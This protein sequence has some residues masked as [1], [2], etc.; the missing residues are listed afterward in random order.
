MPDA[1]P[2]TQ[3]EVADIVVIGAGVSG[4][5]VLNSSK[6]YLPSGS[7]AVLIDG[8]PR[9]GGMWNIAYDYVRL[10]QPHPMFT[11]GAMRWD[12]DKPR[13]YLARRDEV[14]D[15]LARAIGRIEDKFRLDA[16]FGHIVTS[17]VEIQT[18][19]GPMA[20]VTFHPND[21][22]D[23]A[24]TIRARTAVHSAGV[25][26]HCADPLPISSDRVLSIIPQ[27]LGETLA[28][29]PG[30]PVY[31]VGG[32][33]TGMDTILAAAD[34][35]SRAVHLVNG[36][37]TN[38]ISRDVVLPGGLRRWIS[39]RPVSMMFRDLATTF[40]G[41]NEN[42][43]IDHV[44]A[45]YSTA[46]DV[47]NRT[48]LYGLQSMSERARIDAATDVIHGY[49]ED[50]ED[51]PDGPVLRLRDGA[52]LPVP[53]G[54]VFVNCTG[55][56]FRFETMTPM[57]PLISPGGAVLSVNIR[58][59]FH[60][61]SSVA[62]FFTPHL[63]FRGLLRDNGFYALDHE[64]LFRANRNA[65]VGASAAQAYLNQV[66]AMQ[67]L[68]ISVLDRCGLDMDR[69]FPLPRRLL[70]MHRMKSGAA[71]DLPHCKAVLDRVAD[72]FDVLCREIT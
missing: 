44:R 17:C 49:F 67:V 7:K 3:T 18:P 19:D 24:R 65:W 31:V 35:P 52:A 2:Q 68:P 15:H 56:F 60:F 43:L 45:T 58:N 33:K 61:L 10:H 41:D 27:D 64:V 36:S 29:H 34:D 4:L 59:A 25:D 70:A 71:R 1:T 8:K 54:A 26:Y 32:G 48:F 39:G 51:G 53:K 46:P 38:F 6:P 22:P 11:V 55:S 66:R 21:A 12:W 72:R 13:D 50:V 16:H 28:A 9:A 23:E 47:D 14:R 62:G 63:F 37:G 42:A 5:N 57:H 69:W 30:A 20:E 40:D